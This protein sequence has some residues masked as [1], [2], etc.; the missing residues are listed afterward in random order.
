MRVCVYV[1]SAAEVHS[2]GGWSPLLHLLHALA[3]TREI[4]K[5]FLHLWHGNDVCSAAATASV[6]DAALE[7][8]RILHRSRIAFENHSCSQ[9]F[10]NYCVYVCVL[11][12]CV[13]VS[14]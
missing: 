12:V 10:C 2:S 3:I 6:V 8:L 11:F 5:Q 4:C 1:C 9:G 14:A 13:C 7:T